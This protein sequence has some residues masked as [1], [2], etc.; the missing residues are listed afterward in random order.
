MI[1]SCFLRERIQSLREVLTSLKD[2]LRTEVALWRREREELQL[3]REKD[4]AMALEEATAAARAA[5]AAYAAEGPLS[6]NLGNSRMF[7][8][9]YCVVRMHRTDILE[10]RP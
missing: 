4:D 7:V 10:A 8:Q 3:M 2:E 9:F 1:S 5:A 6:N